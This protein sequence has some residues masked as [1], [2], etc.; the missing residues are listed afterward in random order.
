[1]RDQEYRVRMA[2]N[3][4]GFE[5]QCELFVIPFLLCWS[6]ELKPLRTNTCGNGNTLS[7]VQDSGRVIG[8]QRMVLQAR[9]CL[10][11][12]EVSAHG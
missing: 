12:Q 4:P 10:S 2:Y 9:F 6:R 8:V 11:T 5:R 7:F 1:M 3:Q